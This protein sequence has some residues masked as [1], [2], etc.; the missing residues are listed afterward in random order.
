MSFVNAS[1]KVLSLR[2]LVMSEGLNVPTGIY[3]FCIFYNE[4]LKTRL[5]PSIGARFLTIPNQTIQFLL[6]G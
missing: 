4:D 6:G 5:F 2:S 1:F 3:H